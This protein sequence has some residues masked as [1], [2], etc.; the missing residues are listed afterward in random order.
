MASAEITSHKPTPITNLS[1]IPITPFLAS[2]WHLRQKK[3][4]EKKLRFGGSR[5]RV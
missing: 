2:G 3:V 5:I 4:P 1:K